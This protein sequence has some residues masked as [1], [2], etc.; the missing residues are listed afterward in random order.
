MRIKLPSFIRRLFAGP[1]ELRAQ[2]MT[3]GMARPD[4]RVTPATSLSITAVLAC[5]RVLAE[6]VAQLPLHLI[7]D[8]GRTKT[9]LINA[10]L[11]RVLH[12]Q[13]NL[14]HTSFE[15]REMMQAHLALR[16]NAYAYKR[17]SA[18]GQIEEL[19]P[20]D[21][22]RMDVFH[23][24]IVEPTPT[25]GRLGYL[26]RDKFNERYKLTQDEVLHLRGLSFDGVL[27]SRRSLNAAAPSSWRFSQRLTD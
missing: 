15:F 10:P 25:P 6:S 5:V 8:D 23:L 22:D 11:Y 26:Y 20:L 14:R 24:R 18:D 16:G 4:G 27:A 12:A 13:A 9:R 21:P 3:G 7:R 19:V 17:Y 2:A 1:S